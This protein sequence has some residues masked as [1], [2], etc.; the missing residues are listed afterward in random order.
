MLQLPEPSQPPA[1]FPGYD[2][3]A[4]AAAE[5]AVAAAA[6]AVAVIGRECRALGLA[7]RAAVQL[8]GQPQEQIQLPGLFAAP[9]MYRHFRFQRFAHDSCSLR[10]H[11]LV[12]LYA[13]VLVQDRSSL[14]TSP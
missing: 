4:A 13:F 10:S 7:G 1:A 6:A 12:S 2:T 14:K 5:Q 8:Q 11:P 9:G 3:G